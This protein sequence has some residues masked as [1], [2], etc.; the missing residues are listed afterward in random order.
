MV[1]R[2]DPRNAVASMTHWWAGKTR[3]VGGPAWRHECLGFPSQAAAPATQTPISAIQLTDGC[4][5]LSVDTFLL[6][7]TGHIQLSFKQ[8]SPWSVSPLPSRNSP[9]SIHQPSILP[10]LRGDQLTSWWRPKWRVC[11]QWSLKRLILSL[12]ISRFYQLLQ[13][14]H[15]L[16]YQNR[17]HTCQCALSELCICI[18]SKEYRCFIRHILSPL[19]SN[20]FCKGPK[21]LTPETASPH[22]NWRLIGAADKRKRH[23]QGLRNIWVKKYDVRKKLDGQ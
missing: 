16:R 12:P 4:C 15:L 22:V 21:H 3:R 14:M 20:S 23:W 13:S 18:S 7:L 11:R 17:I 2:K 19:T 10:P 6:P 1:H 8:A 9:I 5:W